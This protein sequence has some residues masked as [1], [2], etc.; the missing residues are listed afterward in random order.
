MPRL[1]DYL[2]KGFRES[3]A[4]RLLFWN[5]KAANVVPEGAIIQSTVRLDLVGGFRLNRTE[6]TPARSPYKIADSDYIVAVDASKA[7]VTLELP[8]AAAVG[9]G[10]VIV[11]KDESGKANINNITVKTQPPQKI[12]NA[13]TLIVTTGYSS[14]QLYSNCSN[15][16][17]FG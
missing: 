7:P 6:V 8:S 14:Y 4:N 15:W 11:I 9:T 2:K 16:F 1:S 13:D 3:P 17:V 5:G 10:A 12:D